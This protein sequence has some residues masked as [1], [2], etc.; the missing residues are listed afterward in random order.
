MF[1]GLSRHRRFHRSYFREEE[2]GEL[3]QQIGL[4]CGRVWND[5]QKILTP[6]FAAPTQDESLENL[7]KNIATHALRGYSDGAAFEQELLNDFRE[8][9]AVVRKMVE[10]LDTLIPDDFM[11]IADAKTAFENKELLNRFMNGI[12]NVDALRSA[13]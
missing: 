6:E 9:M 12:K 5:L 10:R 13:D 4:L 11:V 3:E 8:N 7:R 2:S 1:G